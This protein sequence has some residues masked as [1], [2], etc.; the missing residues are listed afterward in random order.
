M[1]PMATR[2]QSLYRSTWLR[3][4]ILSLLGLIAAFWLLAVT[5][6]VHYLKQSIEGY[7]AKIG[8]RIEYRDLRIAPLQLRLELDEVKLSSRQAN[9]TP[10]FTLRRGTLQL[11]LP[12][13]IAGRIGIREIQLSDPQFYV[14]RQLQSGKPGLW[15]WQTFAAAVSKALPPSDPES[16][17]KK[18]ELKRFGVAGLRLSLDD[19]PN[20]YRHD[21]GPI[22]L[23]LRDLANFSK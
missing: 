7:S 20:R 1:N 14:E 10:L 12:S 9:A 4:S 5:W 8:Y 6:G 22:G 23:E 2:I 17:P 11:D 16:P 13:L 18:I 19:Q 3:Y 21:F 15:N